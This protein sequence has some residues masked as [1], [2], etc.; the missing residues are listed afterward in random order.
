MPVEQEVS[1]KV[2]LSGRLSTKLTLVRPVD[3][4]EETVL[5]AEDKLDVL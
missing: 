3:A 4:F 5:T 1:C 2:E